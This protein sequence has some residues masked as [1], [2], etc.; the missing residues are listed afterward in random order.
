MAIFVL[1]GRRDRN[2]NPPTP[3]LTAAIGDHQ[4]VEG[5]DMSPKSKVL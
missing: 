1:M 4:G 2:F 5:I 3:F